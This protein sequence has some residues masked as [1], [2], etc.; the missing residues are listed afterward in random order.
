[1][2]D[3]SGLGVPQ[4]R[5]AA[6]ERRDDRQGGVREACGKVGI[7]DLCH[8]HGRVA[9]A[10]RH[11]LG[12]V[13]VALEHHHIRDLDAPGGEELVEIRGGAL[14]EVGEV[15]HAMV[16]LAVVEEEGGDVVDRRGRQIVDRRREHDHI[17][18]RGVEG[19][20]VEV[21]L[22]HIIAVLGERRHEDA[23][24]IGVVALVVE[25]LAVR[26]GQHG[27]MD[28]VGIGDVHQCRG[29]VLLA[30]EA[31]DAV[32]EGALAVVAV[33][34]VLLL[35]IG[36]EVAHAHHTQLGVVVRIRHDDVA[37]LEGAGV[38]GLVA[39]DHVRVGVR[40]DIAE[41][42]LVGILGVL[43]QQL[44]D[45][46]H[47]GAARLEIALAHQDIDRDGLVELRQVVDAL[48]RDLIDAVLGQV[49]LERV[50]LGEV[51]HQNIQYH[52][53]RHDHAGDGRR[54]AAVAQTLTHRHIDGLLG[55]LRRGCGG[56]R[57]GLFGL[58]GLC[59]RLLSG[60]S[61][62]QRLFLIIC[63]SSPLLSSSGASRTRGR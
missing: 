31:G 59:G 16:I 40:V 12:S 47:I 57:F 21:D 2:G 44:R 33:H 50:A 10:Q 17:V 36:E 58:F 55:L 4:Q 23:E 30:G 20:V 42:D 32:L 62:R 26:G 37:L 22:L 14:R 19:V 13:L 1:M 15:D 54:K 63:H 48:L 34:G 8:R 52:H 56:G 49:E 61:G 7:R 28:R 25:R 35:V 39:V 3:A 9:D 29:E 43:L 53:D 18:L 6:A 11:L 5:D 24:G 27:H 46:L 45:H 38:A 51:A 60:R 41:G